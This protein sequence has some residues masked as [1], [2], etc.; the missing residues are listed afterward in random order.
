MKELLL[1]DV[2]FFEKQTANYHLPKMRWGVV[3]EKFEEGIECLEE[4]HRAVG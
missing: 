2:S 4:L 3:E 1:N